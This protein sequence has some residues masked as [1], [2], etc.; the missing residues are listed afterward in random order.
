MTSAAAMLNTYPADIGDLGDVHRTALL[1]AID[2]TLECAQACTACADACLREPDIAELATCIRL[3]L[4]CADLC[5]TTAR[6]LSRHTGFDANLAMATLEASAQ[7]CRSCG[8]ECARY[9]DEHEQCRVCADAC[10]RC[11]QACQEMVVAIRS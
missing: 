7:A 3:N 10:R 11:E 1:R 9:A 5:E 8:D 2:H 4:D 6:V